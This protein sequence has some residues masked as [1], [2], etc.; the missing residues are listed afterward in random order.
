MNSKGLAGT[1]QKTG[2]ERER[3]TAKTVKNWI[4]EW[5]ERKRSLTTSAFALIACLD[6]RNQSSAQVVLD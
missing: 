6:Q 2:R 4:T 1:M 3:E 5:D